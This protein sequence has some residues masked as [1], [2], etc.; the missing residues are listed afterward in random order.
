LP[1]ADN[2][3]RVAFVGAFVGTA[4]AILYPIDFTHKLAAL[5]G[6]SFHQHSPLRSFGLIRLSAGSSPNPGATIANTRPLSIGPE[7]RNQSSSRKGNA[8]TNKTTA[9]HPF[10]QHQSGSGCC[11]I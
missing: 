7:P 10:I 3:I 11:P 2:A 1:R 4:K 8:M 5:G 6:R 9:V